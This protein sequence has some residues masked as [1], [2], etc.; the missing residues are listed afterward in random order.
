MKQFHYIV[1]WQLSYQHAF[2]KKTIKIGEFLCS[3]LILNMEGN[4]QHFRHIRLYYFKKGKN[5]TKTQKKEKDLCSVWR[6][7]CEQWT[8][9]KWF[10]KFYAGD[11]SPA[12]AP[13]SG[14]PAE[15][16]SNQ[17]KTLIENSQRY[18]TQERANILTISKSIK[19]FMKMKNVSFILRKKAY[20]L[21]GHQVKPLK[22]SLAYIL[23]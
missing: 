5:V 14:R 22:N 18:T 6:R 10:A 13:R 19:L 20:R 16:D 3:H 11:V 7:C 23:S 12:D 8:H 15:V 17:I 4:K 21:F 1:L 9:Q 2:F